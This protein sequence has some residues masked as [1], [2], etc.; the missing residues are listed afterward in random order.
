[1][2][3]RPVS[4]VRSAGPSVQQHSCPAGPRNRSPAR[5]AGHGSP[6]APHVTP[7]QSMGVT[8]CGFS[9]Q[10]A[11]SVPGSRVSHGVRVARPPPTGA[12][13]S[14]GACVPQPPN[15]RGWPVRHV[16]HNPHLPGHVWHKPQMAAPAGRARS[17]GSYRGRDLQ[18][19]GGGTHH[20]RLGYHGTHLHH[21]TGPKSTPSR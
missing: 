7:V 4:V 14:T 15:D 1:M 21:L 9:G 12:V 3:V 5:H 16:P 11:I 10:A 19:T 6:P 17:N 20:G 8:P 18:Q 2:R 13:E